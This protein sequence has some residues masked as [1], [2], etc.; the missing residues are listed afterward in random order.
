M[1]C[2]LKFLLREKDIELLMNEAT[3]RDQL[4][5]ANRYSYSFKALGNNVAKILSM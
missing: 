2:L 3:T 5:V 1:H 4:D